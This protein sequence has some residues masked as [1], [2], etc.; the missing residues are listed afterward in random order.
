MRFSPLNEKPAR[1]RLKEL[2]DPA[3]A[4]QNVQSVPEANVRNLHTLTNINSVR[5]PARVN[6]MSDRLGK[7]W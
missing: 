3:I 7:G 4:A 2:F 1:N 5:R 6:G